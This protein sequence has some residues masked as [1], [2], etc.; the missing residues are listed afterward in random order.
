MSNLGSTDMPKEVNPESWIPPGRS[1]LTQWCKFR[2]VDQGGLSRD[3]CV[4]LWAQLG[5]LRGIA[6]ICASHLGI[7]RPGRISPT[8]IQIVLN[9][10]HPTKVD[11]LIDNSRE[12]LQVPVQVRCQL[13]FLLAWNRVVLNSLQRWVLLVK[14]FCNWGQIWL[15]NHENVGVQMIEIYVGICV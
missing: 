12:L 9:T 7:Q 6:Q 1:F 13:G 14:S 3:L 15:D 11:L 8:Q 4:K 10:D 2:G 5:N